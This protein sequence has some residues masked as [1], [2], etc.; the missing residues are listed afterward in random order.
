M[1][2]RIKCDTIQLCIKMEIEYT[3]PQ[4]MLEIYLF[5]N[6]S[7]GFQEQLN[8]HLISVIKEFWYKHFIN[9]T[10]LHSTS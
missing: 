7:M 8:M 9:I 10:L 2:N 5:N 4:S 6:S 3:C 1:L